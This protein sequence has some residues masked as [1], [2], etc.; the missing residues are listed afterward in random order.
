MK[1]SCPECAF[2]FSESFGV[3]K[4]PE[5]LTTVVVR[6]LDKVTQEVA[7]EV[8]DD[9][10]LQTRDGR[11]AS[12]DLQMGVLDEATGVV[13]GLCALCE[14]FHPRFD[15]LPIKVGKLIFQ[16]KPVREK[17]PDGVWRMVM[18]MICIPMVRGA[19]SCRSCY[20][21]YVKAT[22]LTEYEKK[23]GTPFRREFVTL[24]F[25]PEG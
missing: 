12:V 11:E 10:P 25:S 23:D 24:P 6:C 20:G 16:K 2:P 22:L 15:L 19:F 14:T 21:G 3:L 18:K 9:R 13:T 8:R 1:V 4:C 5:C 17:Q 7:I